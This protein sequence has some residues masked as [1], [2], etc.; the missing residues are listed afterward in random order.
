VSGLSG[1]TAISAGSLSCLAL[2]SDGT[3]WE[4]G[5]DWQDLLWEPWPSTTNIRTTPVQV[6]GLNGVTAI[7]EAR[8]NHMALKSDGTVWAWGLNAHGELGDGTTISRTTPMPVSGL[9]GVTAISAGI[10]HGMALKSDGTVWVWG[11]QLWDHYEPLDP[12]YG[13]PTESHIPEQIPGL[14]GVTAISALSSSMALK[15]DGTVW[16][17]RKVLFVD[18]VFGYQLV[19]VS[20]LSGVIAISEGYYRSLA[21]KS[22]G[23]VWEWEGGYLDDGYNYNTYIPVQVHG[24]N[25]VGYLN[26]LDGLFINSVTADKT[27]PQTA[28]VTVTWTC[29]ADGLAGLEYGWVIYKDGT[30]ISLAPTPDFYITNNIFSLELLLPGTYKVQV[31]VK[32]PDGTII[33][34][35]SDN[36]IV[37]TWLTINS[38]TADKTSPQT[39]PVPVT[40]TCN[41]DSLAGLEYSWVVYKD[42]IP[43]S[44]PP[45]LSSYSINNTFSLN[46]TTSGTYKVEAWVIDPWGNVVT[47]QSDDVVINPELNINSVTADKNSPQMAPVTIIWTCDATGSTELKYD[48][49]VLKNGMYTSWPPIPDFYITNN[50]FSLNIEDPGTYKVEAWV[51]DLYGSVV[52]KQSDEMVIDLAV[53]HNVTFDSNEGSTVDVQTVLKGEYAVEPD[54]DPTKVN[55]DFA[56]WFT[57]DNTFKHEF[58]FANTPITSDIT[59]YARWIS[60]TDGD[61]IPDI[62]DNAPDDPNPDQLDTDGDGIGDAGDNAPNV[63][64]PDQDNSIDGVMEVFEQASEDGSITGNGQPAEN[65]LNEFYAKLDAVKLL[66]DAGEIEAA[67][68]ELKSILAFVDGD[69]SPKDLITGDAANDLK[70]M[71][72]QLILDLE[73][74]L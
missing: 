19:P 52:T 6:A 7:S 2:K 15:S 20:G 44:S 74:Q 70:T 34:K 48:W 72:E 41:A 69:P 46:I 17:L 27:S 59:L 66:I 55:F 18:N 58:D 64:N 53:Y 8:G 13:T 36:I 43:I 1:V 30:C 9:S 73:S 45:I 11:D 51:K 67:I 24:G 38:I 21:L 35:D 12:D 57:D 4:W 68:E 61:G 33:T 32:A 14:N 71:I 47:K 60:D 26:L 23:T 50:T 54:P 25:N 3:V 62:D 22:D 37:N 49:L 63:A 5:A 56:G 40:W 65:K 28:P 29:N 10:C 39:A 31:W 16:E 42:G